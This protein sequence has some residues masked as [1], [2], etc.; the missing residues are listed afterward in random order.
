V[1]GALP[2]L[3]FAGAFNPIANQ[4]AL[5]QFQQEQTL[6]PAAT[7]AKQAEYTEQSALAPIRVQAARREN[8]LQNTEFGERAIGAVA[9]RAQAVDPDQAA[10]VWD[11]GMQALAD[12][13]VP[14]A[15][16]YVG[17]Y[18][19]K[20]A[21]RVADVYGATKPQGPP[22]GFDQEGTER[23]IAQIPA[24]QRAKSLENINM[25]LSGWG[26]VKDEAS[27][28]D[29]VN[30]MRNAGIPVD[31]YLQPG[32]SWQMNYHRAFPAIQR[33]QATQPLLEAQVTQDQGGVP[34]A[35]PKPLYE[36]QST[37]VGTTPEGKPIYHDIHTGQD[38]V[39]NENIIPKASAGLTTFRGKYQAALDLGMPA[40]KALEF[41]NGKRSLDPQQIE[42]WSLSEANKAWDALNYAG[43][44]PRGPR[45]AW[46]QKTAQENMRA[47]QA[48]GWVAPKAGG[49]PAVHPSALPPQ[50]LTALKNA[51]GG[52][53]R[54]NNNQVWK[55]VNGKPVQ[56]R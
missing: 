31:Q 5:A 9:K 27:W 19:P 32:A 49:A 28:D 47:V 7:A 56:V 26:R 18:D 2:E 13:G 29:E 30:A 24:P 40:D 42:Q 36:P 51:R 38:V 11:Q 20:N 54:F 3:D 43:T 33:L 46:V 1:A 44:P 8:A 17:R 35:A 4:S 25:V 21:E 12:Q 16:Q 22:P 41:A 34:T 53:V 37:Y 14:A 52:A 10:Q 6:M 45:D 39:G 23:A 15:S 55:M 50:A 48:A